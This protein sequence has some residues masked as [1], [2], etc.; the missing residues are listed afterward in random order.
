MNKKKEGHCQHIPSNAQRGLG[1]CTRLPL[2]YFLFKPISKV[3]HCD[4]LKCVDTANIQFKIKE[5]SKNVDLVGFKKIVFI[6]I[7]LLKRRKI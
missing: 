7:H 5:E 1:T 2:P 3:S 4:K 6:F